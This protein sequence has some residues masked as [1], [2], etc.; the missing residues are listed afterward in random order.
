MV[1]E[2]RRL[3]CFVKNCGKEL[4]E[5]AIFCDGC[6]SNVNGVIMSQKVK[7]ENSDTITKKSNPLVWVIIVI[8]LA[9]MAIIYFSYVIGDMEKSELE[10]DI[11]RDFQSYMLEDEEYGAIWRENEIEVKQ[12]YLV[13]QGRNSNKY[14]GIV[15]VSAGG[16]IYNVSINV[17]YDGVSYIWETKEPE[18]LDFLDEF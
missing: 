12:V 7:F 10:R 9:I 14:D 8:V 15:E 11:E 6:G 18:D 3:V 5:N 4:N 13:R 2:R 1:T 16:R 17:T